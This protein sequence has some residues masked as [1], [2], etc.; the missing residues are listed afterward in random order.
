MTTTEPTDRMTTLPDGTALQVSDYGRE[1]PGTPLVLVCGTTQ[2]HRLWAPLLPALY[3]QHR[4]ITYDHRGI[5]E[6]TRGGGSISMASLADDLAALLDDPGLHRAHVLGWS[7]GSTVAQELALRH[8]S[9]VAAL[10]LAGTWGRS[11]VFQTCV[12][13][14]HLQRNT[15][16]S[17]ASVVKIDK[18]IPLKAAAVG[19][20]V[21]TGWG[22][23]VKSAGIE[24]GDTV[25]VMGIGGIGANALQG[26]AHAGA[27]TVIAV[28][29]VDRKREWAAQFGATHAFATIEQA[30]DYARSITNGQGA[31]ATIVTIGALG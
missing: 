15:A 31:D 23:A 6:S 4:V 8:P 21:P 22:S 9:R 3:A 5:G 2:S 26:A 18:D 17:T 13:H 7:L 28:D 24:P 29:P 12:R 20:A 30:A 11:D 25:I 10:V 27:A 19:C 14:L 16:A 1:R